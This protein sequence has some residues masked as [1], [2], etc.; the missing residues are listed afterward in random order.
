MA[1]REG[2]RVPFLDIG[3]AAPEESPRGKF[4]ITGIWD[5]DDGLLRDGLDG[6]PLAT[7][8]LNAIRRQPITG[9]ATVIARWDD[10][11]PLLVRRAAE[12]GAAW[13]FGT[14]PDYEWSN[15]GDGDLLL[16][17]VQRAIIDGADRFDTG[18]L[19]TVG[20]KDASALPGQDR[21]RIDDFGTPDPANADY[22]AGV[23]DIDG[24]VIAANRPSNENRVEQL[25]GESLDQVLAGTDYSLFQETRAE[26]PDK[27]FREGWRAFLLAMILFLFGEALLC[28][29]ARPS[30]DAAAD[31]TAP[32]PAS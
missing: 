30:G 2:I 17:A 28:L 26:E 10:E 7:E 3:W 20:T 15:I 31:P 9:E 24:R 25:T 12:R 21:Q 13:F 8:S 16:P 32:Q 5:R 11:S 18:H 1:V 6:T 4:F 19:T 22:E 29:P 23:W 27:L 14:L